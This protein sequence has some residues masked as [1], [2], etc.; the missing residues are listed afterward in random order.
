MKHLTVEENRERVQR[1]LTVARA[2]QLRG[3]LVYTEQVAAA[4]EDLRRTAAILVHLKRLGIVDQSREQWA[5][6]VLSR[7]T[8]TEKGEHVLKL[9][10]AGRLD[11]L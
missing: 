5:G 6:R 10:L 9:S 1:A 7:W 8:I 3:P 11:D 4:V 2:V